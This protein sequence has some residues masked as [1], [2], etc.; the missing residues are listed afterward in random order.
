M[1]G[2]VSHENGNDEADNTFRQTVF[3]PQPAQPKKLLST[4]A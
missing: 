1:D 2:D 3:N 4:A